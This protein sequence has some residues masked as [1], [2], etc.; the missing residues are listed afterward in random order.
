MPHI[1]RRRQIERIVSV[2]S[3]RSLT[4]PCCTAAVPQLWPFCF[5]RTYLALACSLRLMPIF[6][7]LLEYD[8]LIRTRWSI[9]PDYAATETSSAVSEAVAV[10]AAAAMPQPQTQSANASRVSVV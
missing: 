4:T 9:G 8:V 6:I 2:F 7:F 5:V 1:N 3:G 10:A